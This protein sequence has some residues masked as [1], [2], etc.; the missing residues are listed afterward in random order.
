M[1]YA[2][3]CIALGN[4]LQCLVPVAIQSSSPELKRGVKL[5][6]W[7]PAISTPAQPN[8]CADVL[9]IRKTHS[10]NLGLPLPHSAPYLVGDLKST[11]F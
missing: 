10:N 4:A 11:L 3:A 5:L 6:A 2:L 9:T 8:P 1:R 7:M